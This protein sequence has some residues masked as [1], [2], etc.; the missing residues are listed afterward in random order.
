M[1]RGISLY[2]WKP[3][4]VLMDRTHFVSYESSIKSKMKY[5]DL[6]TDSWLHEK[7]VTLMTDLTMSQHV[8]TQGPETEWNAT[9]VDD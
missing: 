1:R 8:E 5:T 2:I 9:I 7:P 6:Y 4:L 3:D